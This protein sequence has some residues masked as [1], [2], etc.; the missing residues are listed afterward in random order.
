[1]RAHVAKHPV[2]DSRSP[3][4]DRLRSLETAAKQLALGG[5]LHDVLDR[6][7]D[8]V[9]DAVPAL[10]HDLAI[11]LPN[12]FKHSRSRGD[13][14]AA[15]E[16]PTRPGRHAHD[17]DRTRAR[18]EVSGGDVLAVPVTSG[19]HSYGTLVAIAPQDSHF[20]SDDR[21]ILAAYA[22]HAAAGIEMT[23]LLAE[24]RE[25][26]ETAEMLLEAARPLSEQYTV[27]DVAQ[28]ISEAALALSGANRSGVALWDSDIAQLRFHG[29]TGWRG[30]LAAKL[31]DFVLTTQESPELTD[32]LINPA[33]LLVDGRGSSWAKSM[34]DHFELKALLAV[35]ILANG[36]FQGL[37]IAH[38]D[39]NAPDS[40]D[41]PAV[42]RLSGLAGLASVAL[43][44]VQLM[45]EARCM[46]LRDPLTGL[47]N[48]TLFEEKLQAALEKAAR[49][50]HSVGVLL[51]DI[52]RFKRVN[53]SLGHG[54]GDEVLRQVATRLGH[55]VDD[56]DMLARINGDQFAVVT[57]GGDADVRSPTIIAKIR[58]AFEKPLNTGGEK[59][60]V[61]VAFGVATSIG[62]S[63]EEAGVVGNSVQRIIGLA[64]LDLH[65][66]KATITGH[67]H[68]DPADADRLRLETDLRGAASRG[69]LRVHYQP[70]IDLANGNIVGVE[71]LVRWEHPELGM[72]SPASFIP[73]AEESG[74][75]REIGMHVLQEATRTGASWHK[76][77]FPVEMAVNV[78]V[79][80]L[81]APDF[82]S[83]VKGALHQTGFPAASLTIEITESQVV[84]DHAVLRTV[85]EELRELGA[86]LSIDDFGTGFSSLTQLQRMPV[87]EIKID[88]A[89]TT[90][91]TTS[92]V[93]PFLAGI[94]GLG[95]GLSLRVIAEGVET[96]EQLTAVR[97]AGCDRAQGY[98]LGRPGD[99]ATILRHLKRTA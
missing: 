41:H 34:L 76:A 10:R 95:H 65:R 2:I 91:L 60:F 37:V 48:R 7:I 9:A 27:D 84:T 66:S 21:A 78:S 49:I 52:S 71:A 12:G 38:W 17:L 97:A 19:T 70:Q 29:A 94:V 46:A 59:L 53:E 93:S 11:Q 40:L 79:A 90:E 67:V 85:L 80:Q 42:R 1:M 4:L 50:G 18:A 87:T 98:L 54:A 28:S 44:N 96:E 31:S 30:A 51:C 15:A 89:F 43:Q 82:L 72:I 26:R 86:G 24:S 69:E 81:S 56:G 20:S 74:L 32:M 23:S 99:A 13:H 92:A 88:R 39:G 64:D 16:A 63:R 62:L 6:V 83:Q 22:H 61:D 3:E 58:Q 75:I 8:G 25:Q 36:D 35:P 14:E 57:S 68:A 33:P 47:A 45:D 73:I 77:G 5:S 55:C